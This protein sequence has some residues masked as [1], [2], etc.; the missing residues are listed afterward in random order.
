MTAT[1]MQMTLDGTEVPHVS[2]VAR[3]NLTDAQR[4]ILRVMATRCWITSTEAG[5]VVQAHARDQTEV[6]RLARRKYAATDGLAAM[7]R[8]ARRGLVVRVEPGAWWLQRDAPD[9][10][11]PQPIRMHHLV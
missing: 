10:E 1:A 8:L 11:P 6:H 3:S 2:L 4:E 5:I 9:L 7:Y